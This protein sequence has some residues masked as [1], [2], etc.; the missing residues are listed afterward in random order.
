MAVAAKLA[1]PDQ[2]PRDPRVTEAVVG[3]LAAHFGNRLVTSRA[4]REQ[5]GNTLTW[6]DNQPPDAVVFPQETADVQKAVQICAK[7][8]FPVIPFG[9]GTSLEG[10]ISAPH[11]GVSLDLSDMNRIL[12]VH[13]ED[14]D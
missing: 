6:I 4:V 5:H 12:E 9:A 10:H 14:H 8:K 2:T 13:T 7:Y 3:E 11:G 1:T